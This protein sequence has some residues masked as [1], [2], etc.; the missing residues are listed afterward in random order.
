MNR[1]HSESVAASTLN[2]RK[3][4]SAMLAMVITLIACQQFLYWNQPAEQLIHMNHAT[5]LH[6]LSEVSANG[7]QVSGRFQASGTVETFD[8][9][10]RE[11]RWV[12]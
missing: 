2:V 4:L 12:F 6:R 5:S 11:P 9:A 7:N 8:Q 1:Q 3:G 10:P